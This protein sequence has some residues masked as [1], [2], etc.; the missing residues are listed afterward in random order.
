MVSPCAKPLRTIVLEGLQ[1]EPS[2]PAKGPGR[3]ANH[4][5]FF[6]SRWTFFNNADC[7]MCRGSASRGAEQPPQQTRRRVH[8]PA[9]DTNG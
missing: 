2:R 7:V 1:D 6:V 8:A 9:P 3:F 4:Q 5:G